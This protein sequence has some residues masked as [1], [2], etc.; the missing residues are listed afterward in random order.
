M[1]L[2]CVPTNLTYTSP[3]TPTSAVRMDR[4]MRQFFLERGLIK[5]NCFQMQMVKIFQ[6][7]QSTDVGDW[8]AVHAQSL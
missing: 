7:V 6:R 4:T 2:S 8:I 5:Y 1:Y 3:S